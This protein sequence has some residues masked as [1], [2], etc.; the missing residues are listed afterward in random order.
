MKPLTAAAG[1]AI[2]ILSMSGCKRE[3]TGQVAAVVDGEEVTLQEINA[4]IGPNLPENADKKAVQV[5]ALQRVVD[6]RL[7]ANAAKEDGL[8]KSADYLVRTRQLNDAL[9]VQ[10][11][12][13]KVT[14]SVKVPTPAEATKF[15]ADRPWM[16]ADRRLYLVDRIQFAQPADPSVVKALEPLRTIQEVADKLTSLDIR[17]ARGRSQIDSAQVPKPMLD[18]ILAL[19]PGEPFL[20]PEGNTINISSI[21]DSRPAPIAGPE[22]S[23]IAVQLMRQQAV[24]DGLESRLKTLRSSTDI[25]YQTGFGPAS[26]TAT[27]AAATGAA[28]PAA[29]DAPPKP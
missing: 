29:T 28:R 15:M 13:E 26:A 16:F 22:A 19:P 7:L 20:T 1:A 12:T 11:L 27:G 10:L 18:R 4:E 24:R 9:L 8:D 25:E 6:R 21:V 2:L 3:A 17:F 23:P 5:A 14:Q